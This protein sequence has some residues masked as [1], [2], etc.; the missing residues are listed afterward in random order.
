MVKTIIKTSKGSVEVNRKY[1]DFGKYV[2]KQCIDKDIKVGD[3]AHAVGYKSFPTFC[4]VLNGSIHPKGIEYKIIC[5]LG[6]VYEFKG[7]TFKHKHKYCPLG[8]VVLKTLVD[9]DMTQAELASALGT[10]YYKLNDLLRGKTK[11]T[12]RIRRSVC[13]HLQIKDIF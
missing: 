13:Q 8:R 3:L 6:G 2:L 4:K 12:D 9:R 11:R 10:N 1:T 7:L 5:A